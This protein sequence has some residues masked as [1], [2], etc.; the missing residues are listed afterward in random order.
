MVSGFCV[1]FSMR[2]S[3]HNVAAKK[4]ENYFLIDKGGTLI[5]LQLF[6]G[7]RVILFAQNSRKG[8]SSKET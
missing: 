2:E 5:N 6:W 7:H 8:R 3:N 4:D 1:G